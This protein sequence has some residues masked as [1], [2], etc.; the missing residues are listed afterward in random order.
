MHRHPCALC[1]LLRCHRRTC[2]RRA[3]GWTRRTPASWWRW[4][5]R[6]RELED[7]CYAA[8]WQSDAAGTSSW[9]QMDWWRGC[10]QSEREC[11]HRGCA[12]CHSGCACGHSGRGSGY[13]VTEDVDMVTANMVRTAAAGSFRPLGDFSGE[14]AGPASQPP[15]ARKTAKGQVV[16]P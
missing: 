13:M 2:S 14:G 16:E 1:P 10:G 3:S 12:C 11:G 4:S 6:C 5:R 15:L 7:G 8:N 9:R